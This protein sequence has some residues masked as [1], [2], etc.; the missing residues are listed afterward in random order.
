MKYYTD[1]II[2]EF[3]H[4]VKSQNKIPWNDKLFK[5]NDSVKKLDGKRR[6]TFHTF[7]MKAM[8]LCK[9]ARLYMKPVISYLRTKIKEPNQS[10]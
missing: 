7:F 3:T 2:E 5:V 6:A 1:N 4:E 10:D 8:F 9:R